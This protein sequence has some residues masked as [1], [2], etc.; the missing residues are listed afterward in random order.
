MCIEVYISSQEEKGKKIHE[1]GKED[2]QEVKV[3]IRY[4]DV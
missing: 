4:N 2:L 1:K 3:P